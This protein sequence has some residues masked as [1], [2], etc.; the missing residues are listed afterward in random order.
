MHRRCAERLPLLSCAQRSNVAFHGT[1]SFGVLLTNAF[2]FK[3]V[4][5]ICHNA[6][7]VGLISVAG[8]ALIL[9]YVSSSLT[10][11]VSVS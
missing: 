1:L 5:V 9:Q 11:R 7:E 2:L 4:H 6:I 8:L 10:V 3:P